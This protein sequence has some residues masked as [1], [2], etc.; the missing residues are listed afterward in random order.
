MIERK[1]ILN[2]ITEASTLTE[3]GINGVPIIEIA[4]EKRVLI[5]NHCGM[6]EYGPDRIS[7]NVKYGYITVCGEQLKLLEMT[8]EKLVIHGRI[9]SVSLVRRNNR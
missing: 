7:V 3:N 6:R 8:R 2:R 1:S 9:S 4:G 5:E